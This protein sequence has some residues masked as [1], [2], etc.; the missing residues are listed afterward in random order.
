MAATSCNMV[1]GVVFVGR[2]IKRVNRA[3]SWE[4]ME[5]KDRWRKEGMVREGVRVFSFIGR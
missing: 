2:H 1:G 3:A 5:N 4:T